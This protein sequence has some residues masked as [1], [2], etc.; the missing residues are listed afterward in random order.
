MKQWNFFALVTNLSSVFISSP[1]L[2]P[3]LVS[4]PRADQLKVEEWVKPVVVRGGSEGKRRAEWRPSGLLPGLKVDAFDQRGFQC[5]GEV[6]ERLQDSDEGVD[7]G[8]VSEQ[9]CVLV[10]AQDHGALHQ[11]GEPLGQQAVSVE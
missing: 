9:G 6:V 2:P 4:N 1:S 7:G 8:A 10:H 5:D 11:Q 3:S